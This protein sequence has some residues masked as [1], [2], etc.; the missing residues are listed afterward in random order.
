MKE[1][2]TLGSLWLDAYSTLNPSDFTDGAG[3][4]KFTPE[5]FVVISQEQVQLPIRS[6][7]IATHL[8]DNPSFF[9]K[10]T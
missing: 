7:P 1:T 5:A 2:L 9:R 4:T 8:H 6:S 3:G 10:E